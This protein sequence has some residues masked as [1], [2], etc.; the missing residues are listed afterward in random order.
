MSVGERPF[1]K[2]KILIKFFWRLF[3]RKKNGRYFETLMNQ[4]FG[5]RFII[6]EKMRYRSKLMLKLRAVEVLTSFH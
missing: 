5:Q 2:I 1:K 3:F 4:I 6:L